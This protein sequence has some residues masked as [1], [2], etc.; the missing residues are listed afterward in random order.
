MTEPSTML[1]ISCFKTATLVFSL[2]NPMQGEPLILSKNAWLANKIDYRWTNPFVPQLLESMASRFDSS[3]IAETLHLNINHRM[4]TNLQLFCSKDFYSGRIVS[5]S[6]VVSPYHERLFKFNQNQGWTKSLESVADLPPERR[7]DDEAVV[8][9][10]LTKNE[11][12]EVDHCYTLSSLVSHTLTVH[13]RQGPSIY[14]S[15][16]N[17]YIAFR[18]SL[19]R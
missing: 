10:S 1:A 11:K 9:K 2:G 6:R 8:R 13:I 15:S 5:A 19:N 12:S 4:C 18:D 14:Q 7:M 3:P 17:V 16:R